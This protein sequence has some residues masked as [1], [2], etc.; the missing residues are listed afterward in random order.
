MIL[1][2]SSLQIRSKETQVCVNIFIVYSLMLTIS[3]FMQVTNLQQKKKISPLP[4]EVD[5]A[6][7]LGQYCTLG[8]VDKL[9]KQNYNRAGLSQLRSTGTE[10]YA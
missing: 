5:R 3:K 7:F 1:K 6:L 10:G 2:I 4:P 8:N 9:K